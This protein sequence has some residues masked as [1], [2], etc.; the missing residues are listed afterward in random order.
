M[1]IKLAGQPIIAINETEVIGTVDGVLISDDKISYIYHENADINFVIPIDKVTIGSDAVM[2]RSIADM[3][4]APGNIKVLKSKSGI[5]S[6]DG[7]YLGYLY[8][9]EVNDSFIVQCLHTENTAIEMPTIIKYGSIIVVDLEADIIGRPDAFARTV[10]K[11][12]P[13]WEKASEEIVEAE[14]SQ[15]EE[16][17]EEAEAE[18]SQEEE[19]S[20]EVEAE[21]SQEEDM[22]GKDEP[23]NEEDGPIK[24][25]IIIAEAEEEKAPKRKSKAQSIEAPAEEIVPEQDNALMEEAYTIKVRDI[26][27]ETVENR[28]PAD[29]EEDPAEARDDRQAEGDGTEGIGLSVIRSKRQNEEKAG[30]HDINTKYTYLCGKQLLEEIKIGERYYDKGATIDAGLIKHAIANNAIVKVIV[31]AED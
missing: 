6:F 20:E 5:Y 26:A 3:A 1:I 2:T 23:D 9:I 18:S 28:A 30:G 22:P 8:G 15:E 7:K 14:S 11:F 31:N 12:T 16:V 29:E 4:L 19:V 10:P 17:S 25:E 13:D 21:S 24:I 27:V